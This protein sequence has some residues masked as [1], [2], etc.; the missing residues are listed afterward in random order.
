MVRRGM[1]LG[2][3][4]A[5]GAWATLRIERTFRRLTPQGAAEALRGAAKDVV[6]DVRAALDAGRGAMRDVDERAALDAPARPEIARK[7]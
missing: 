7:G 6:V 2:L 4:V 1:W 3:G 5:L